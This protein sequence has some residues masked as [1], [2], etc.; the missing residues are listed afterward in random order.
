M[1]PKKA[2]NMPKRVALRKESVDRNGYVGV[3]VVLWALSLSARRA[4]IEMSAPQYRWYRSPLS[5]S[6][7]RAWIEIGLLACP[8]NDLIRSLSA[9]RAWIEIVANAPC[10]AGSSV[11]LRKESVDRNMALWVEYVKGRRSLSARRAWIEMNIASV[12][13]W[14]QS[15][16]LRKE[17]VDRNSHAKSIL[18]VY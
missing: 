17:S 7:R 15:V 6:A 10:P 2:Y 18:S 5:L 12:N 3:L 16:A 1:W 9:R 8:L 13:S 4:W 11:A 14:L